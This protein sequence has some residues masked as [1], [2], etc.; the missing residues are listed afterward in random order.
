MPVGWID[1]KVVA[2]HQ[3]VLRIGGLENRDSSG[4]QY[5]DGLVDQFDQSIQGEML[6][7]VESGHGAD[8]GIRQRPQVLEC[9]FLSDVQPFLFAL[10]NENAIGIN[11]P[12]FQPGFGK[13]FQPLAAAAADV[14]YRHPPD[15]DVLLL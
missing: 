14:Q 6:D 4:L 5:A 7:D 15:A 11:S 1:I 13:Q 10:G 3:D 8:T 12:R 2:S 9:V